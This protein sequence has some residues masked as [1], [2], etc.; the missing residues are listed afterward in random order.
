MTPS[1]RGGKRSLRISTQDVRRKMNLRATAAL[2][3]PSTCTHPVLSIRLFMLACAHPCT[4]KRV[5]P[6][7]EITL[8]WMSG[9]N[10][11][12]KR[13]IVKEGLLRPLLRRVSGG[14]HVVYLFVFRKY[15]PLLWERVFL[16]RASLHEDTAVEYDCLFWFRPASYI[17]LFHGTPTERPCVFA[18]TPTRAGESCT[19]DKGI[20]TAHYL[21][22]L[23]TV[24]LLVGSRLYPRSTVRS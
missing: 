18:K 3:S 6:H 19:K 22:V 16:S 21:H 15:S 12:C 13:L 2:R 4:F 24:S 10:P 17:H 23:N 9:L 20:S 5:F 14:F 1:W 7:G 11:L 8:V